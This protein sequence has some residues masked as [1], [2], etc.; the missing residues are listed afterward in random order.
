[1]KILIVDQT[2]ASTR[3]AGQLQLYAEMAI[4]RL[5]GLNRGRIAQLTVKLSTA[6]ATLIVHQGIFAI[7]GQETTL[8]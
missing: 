8:A 3:H 6:T 7:L 1:M 4:V 5:T 2:S